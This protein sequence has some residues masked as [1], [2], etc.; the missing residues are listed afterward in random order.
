VDAYSPAN[1]VVVTGGLALPL[2]RLGSIQGSVHFLPT[3]H[4]VLVSQPGSIALYTNNLLT[5]RWQVQVQTFLGIY[6]YGQAVIG[7]PFDNTFCLYDIRTGAMVQQVPYEGLAGVVAARDDYILA[8]NPY[9]KVFEAIAWDGARLWSI[10][11]EHGRVTVTNTV[12]LVTKE[13]NEALRCVDAKTGSLLWTFSAPKTGS[14]APTDRSNAMVSGF[15][16]VA[17]VSDRVLVTL[18]DFRVFA[19]SLQTGEVL[20]TMRPPF[21]G[22]YL[23]T[24]KC[25]YFQQPFGLSEFDHREMKEVDRTEYREDVEPLYGGHEI[26]ANGFWLTEE[27]VFW[28]TM[29]GAIMGVSRTQGEGGKRTVWVDLLQN[30]IMP[31]GVPP[32]GYGDKLYCAT[33]GRASELLCWGSG[34]A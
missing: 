32:V 5:K 31:I 2:R 10:P 26:T 16:S 15:P 17:V 30:A 25:I 7:G 33:K 24:E 4:G 8:V 27:S 6:R 20:K 19:L 28:T 13:F 21:V 14:G 9:T 34:T 29:H 22:L 1:I 23:V 18:A 11:S 12:L 3:E